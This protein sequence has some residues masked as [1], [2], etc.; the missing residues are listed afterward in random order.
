MLAFWVSFGAGIG[1]ALV[2]ALTTGYFSL[3]AVERSY[4]KQRRNAE[5][6]EHKVIM[7]LLQAIH[8]EIE[9]VCERY[10]ETMGATV[11]SLDDGHALA[12]YYPLMSDY[13]S[14]YNGNAFLIGRVPDNDLRKQIVKTYTRMK[15]LIDSYRM[16]NELV[17]KFEIASEIAQ[18]S[19]QQ[20]HADRVTIRYRVLVQYAAKLKQGH[21]EFKK[22]ADALLR[23][24]RKFGVLSESR[25]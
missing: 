20:I 7:G 23:L 25:I 14:V 16:N 22:E 4:K 19:G 15:G 3:A 17:R 18:E 21:R 11:E 24:L 13:F 9:S 2:G 1:G 10:D 6:A 8:D 5:E 12:V